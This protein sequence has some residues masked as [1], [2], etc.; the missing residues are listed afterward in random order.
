MHN[1]YTLL[2]LY[3]HADFKAWKEC[4]EKNTN[5]WYVQTSGRKTLLDCGKTYYYCNR[6]GHFN[7]RGRGQRHLKIQGS[8]KINSYCAAAIT[9]TRENVSGYIEVHFCSTHYGHKIA[10]GH[11]RLIESDKIA[12]A[13]QLAQGI[14]FQHILDNMRDNLGKDFRRIH[15]LT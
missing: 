4:L 5:S 3:A 14:E 13:G 15:L 6:S 2:L 8:S 11:L 1:V 12:I 10:L 9:V 7:S